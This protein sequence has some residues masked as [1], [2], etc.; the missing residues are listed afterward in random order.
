MLRDELEPM[1]S[2]RYKLACAHIEDSDQT[3]RP[4]SLIRAIDGRSMGCQ[5]SNVSTGRKYSL[6]SDCADAQS[7]SLYAHVN[8]YLCCIPA[9]L[10]VTLRSIRFCGYSREP[11]QR[12][13]SL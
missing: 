3:A 6:Y 9:H 8:L 5:G 4:R 12:N 11:S 2:K 7:D 1:S 10:S 13:S